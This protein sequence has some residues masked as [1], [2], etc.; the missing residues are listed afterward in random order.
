[1]KRV[2]EPGQLADQT[3]LG[4]LLSE[5]EAGGEQARA[6]LAALPVPASTPHRLGITGSPGT[7]KSTLAARL[8]GLLRAAG[9]RVGVV[10]VDPTSPFSGGAILGDRLR[11]LEHQLDPGV[12]IRSLASRGSLGG[13]APGAGATATVLEAAGYSRILIETV[14]VGQT[15]YDVICLADTVV[16]LLSPES[17]DAVQLLKAGVL[18]IGDI[19]AVNKSDRPGAEALMKEL[20]LSLDLNSLT[21]TDLLHH[22]A[23]SL[24]VA[25][26]TAAPPATEGNGWR[27][28][29]VRLI[30]KEGEGVAELARAVE[31]HRLWLQSLGPE[32][33][34]R[35]LRLAREITFSLRAELANLLDGILAPEVDRLAHEV[36]EGNLKLWDAITM[37][38][39]RVRSAL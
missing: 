25:A 1:M 6:V 9:E 4:R 12:F 10:A 26:I 35:R 17:G 15:G 21:S 27:P 30:A 31:A 29:V 13:V 19:F 34:R 22:G 38:R 32:H 7:G 24:P 33:P 20:E 11:L 14:G 5:V 16:V 18:E 8:I 36:Q 3:S 37:L 39:A 28:P 2:I 23:G